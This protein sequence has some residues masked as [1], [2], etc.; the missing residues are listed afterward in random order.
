MKAAALYPDDEIQKQVIRK[1]LLLDWY[2]QAALWAVIDNIVNTGGAAVGALRTLIDL[3][4]KLER[5]TDKYKLGGEFSPHRDVV[6]IV[7]RLE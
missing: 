3:V 5:A 1:K 7:E 6:H 4:R 2:T